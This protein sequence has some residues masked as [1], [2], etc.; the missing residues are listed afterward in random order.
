MSHH[1][2][3]L[4]LYKSFIIKKTTKQ[5]M[6]L[7]HN[8]ALFL[9]GMVILLAHLVHR[10]GVLHPTPLLFMLGI[11]GALL[12][13]RRTPIAV[14]GL[15]LI[16]LATLCEPYQ[17]GIA[18]VNDPLS[19]RELLLVLGW[20]MLGYGAGGCSGVIVGALAGLLHVSS[21]RDAFPAL[22][23][24]FVAAMIL[25]WYYLSKVYKHRR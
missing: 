2:I 7:E 8:G 16:A 12:Q 13:V 6:M 20:M 1:H 3:I 14:V 23:P 22:H 24:L 5:L 21:D 25:V 15:L 19:S 18:A 11:S 4:L 17:E 9:S 10:S